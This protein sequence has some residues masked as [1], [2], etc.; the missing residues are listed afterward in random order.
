MRT[1]TGTRV[2]SRTG[3][4]AR[5]RPRAAIPNAAPVLRPMSATTGMEVAG[6]DLRQPL[7]EETTRAIRRALCEWGVVTFRDQAIAPAQHLAFARRFG[8][9]PPSEF[10]VTAPGFPQIG[11][12][13]KEPDQTRNVGGNWHSD[14]SFDPVPP[15]GAVLYARELPARGGDTLFANMAAAYDS[16]SDGL[17]ETLS[18]LRAVHAKRNAFHADDRPERRPSAAQRAR[19]DEEYAGRECVHPVITTHPETGRRVL[20][21]NP[22]YTV[23]FEGW[24]GRESAPLLQYLHAHATRPENT[25]RFQWREGSIA[26][27]DNR[28]ALH[29]AL[30]DY[31]G[32]R[33]LMHR[34][35]VAG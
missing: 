32:A 26:F 20:F 8:E 11:E 27:W 35:V 14:H 23:R 33:R 24:T 28:T 16:L 22:T 4:R 6:V 12:I 30:N 3:P 19:F 1:T 9:V 15:L 2:R 25:C 5:A 7:P 18:S 29:Y 31:H 21:V 13:R 34:A 17:R 10:L